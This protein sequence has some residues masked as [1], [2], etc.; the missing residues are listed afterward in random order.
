[1]RRWIWYA[2]CAALFLTAAWIAQPT[3]QQMR[4]LDLLPTDVIVNIRQVYDFGRLIG[5]R[6][7]VF[8]KVGDSITVSDNFL[9]PIGYGVYDLGEYGYL[10]AVIDFYRQTPARTGNSFNNV[11][12]AAGVGWSAWAVLQPEFANPDECLPDEMPLVC[13]YRVTQPS[14]ALIMFGTNE[15]SYM[16]AAAY[17]SWLVRIIDISEEMGV[18]PILSTLPDRHAWEEAIDRYNT[19]IRTLTAER[20]LPLIE[21]AEALRRLPDRGLSW[22]GIHPSW[23]PDAYYT[24]AARFTSDNLR[25]G[26]VVRNLTA[27]QTLDRVWRSL[28]LSGD[29]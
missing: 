22:D 15:V 21:Y 13:E 10:R 28:G 12:L 4:P 23:T 25:Y 29:S 1:M 18:I 3:S 19:V 2:F 7:T 14:L 11:S 9:H 27:L 8:S 17:R 5:N 16:S 6:P 20:H 24:G 26:Y